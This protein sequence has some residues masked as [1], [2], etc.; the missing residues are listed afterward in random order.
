ME[1]AMWRICMFQRLSCFC[2]DEQLLGRCLFSP[3]NGTVIPRPPGDALVLLLR[4]SFLAP[5]PGSGILPVGTKRLFSPRFRERLQWITDDSHMSGGDPH[6]PAGRLMS[7]I[8]VSGSLPLIGYIYR[9]IQLL[10]GR[11]IKTSHLSAQC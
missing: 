2:Q 11:E 6:H 4:V 3:Q 9:Y 7:P 8:R 5:F 10:H 1:C